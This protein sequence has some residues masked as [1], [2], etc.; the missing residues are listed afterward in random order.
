MKRKIILTI[1]IFFPWMFLGAQNYCEWQRDTTFYPDGDYDVILKSDNIQY[2][3]FFYFHKDEKSSRYCEVQTG[4][5]VR[6]TYRRNYNNDLWTIDF[7]EERVMDRNQLGDSMYVHYELHYINSIIPRPFYSLKI[8]YGDTTN[9]SYQSNDKTIAYF[10]WN[11]KNNEWNG[12]KKIVNAKVCTETDTCYTTT[13]YKKDKNE[14]KPCYTREHRNVSVS[15]NQ[16]VNRKIYKWNKDWVLKYECFYGSGNSGLY[17]QKWNKSMTK[18]KR[19][20]KCHRKRYYNLLLE[21]ITE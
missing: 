19:M 9:F 13:I 5:D 11:K 18:C 6:W 15:G 12:Y 7:Q 3:R 4:S 21:P 10:R 14:W 2:R 8:D 17:F 1:E 16:N 20:K